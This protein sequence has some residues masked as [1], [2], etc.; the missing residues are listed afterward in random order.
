MSA[1][2][3]IVNGYSVIFQD[4]TEYMQSNGKLYHARDR[5]ADTDY[6]IGEQFDL[7]KY[8]GAPATKVAHIMAYQMYRETHRTARRGDRLNH[9]RRLNT[10]SRILDENSGMLTKI[11][12]MFSESHVT[13]KDRYENAIVGAFKALGAES[14]PVS[15]NMVYPLVCTALGSDEQAAR[16]GIAPDPYNPGSLK[17]IRGLIRS[18]V[19]ERC[20]HSRQHHFRAG[21]RVYW[22]PGDRTLLF[23]NYGL[24]QK[25]EAIAWTPYKF[26][27]GDGWML[28]PEAAAAYSMPSNEVLNAA[29]A[30]YKK[31]GMRGRRNAT[32][33]MADV[34]EYRREMNTAG[35]TVAAALTG[36]MGA[37]VGY[38]AAPAIAAY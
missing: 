32:P 20:P 38:Y 36:F 31:Q 25:N 34:T 8:L 21:K 22:K 15:F 37:A 14:T 18:W 5:A 35:T 19:E 33:M 29:A 2:A 10:Y 17:D 24:A 30:L 9:A 27:R 4:G 26:V 16:Y 23:V 7:R 28:N 3:P 11:A 12:N 1:L 13:L 6:E